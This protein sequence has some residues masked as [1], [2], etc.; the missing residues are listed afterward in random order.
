MRLLV[1]VAGVDDAAAALA[2]GADLIDAKDPT[3][4][5]LGAVSHAVLQDI[6]AVVAGARPVTAALGNASDEITV[7]EAARSAAEAGVEFVKIGFDS[8]RETSRI[9]EL[10]AAAVRG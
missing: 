3:R 5:A 7:E 1:S 4:G 6:R 2:G 8:I 10:I 9:S